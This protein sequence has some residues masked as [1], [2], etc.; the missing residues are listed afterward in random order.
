MQKNPTCPNC[1]RPMTFVRE[2]RSSA[3]CPDPHVFECMGCLIVL[4]TEDHETLAGTAAAEPHGTL[5]RLLTTI[6]ISPLK[7]MTEGSLRPNTVADDLSNRHRT[8]GSRMKL[9]RS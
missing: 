3:L 8:D 7:K 5:R 6:S 4:M 2:G 9:S 1:G